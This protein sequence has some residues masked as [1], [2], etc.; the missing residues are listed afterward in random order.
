MTRANGR[1]TEMEDTDVNTEWT[2]EILTDPSD[3][4]NEIK[5][6]KVTRNIRDQNACDSSIHSFIH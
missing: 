5:F 3:G 1:E 6:P 4:V 2:S